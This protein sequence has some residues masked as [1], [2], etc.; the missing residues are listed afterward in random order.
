MVLNHWFILF[1]HTLNQVKRWESLVLQNKIHHSIVSAICTIN[2]SWVYCRI[3]SRGHL[4][5]Y[6][7]QCHSENVMN[8]SNVFILSLIACCR[9]CDLTQQATRRRYPISPVLLVMSPF[10]FCSLCPGPRGQ[11]RIHMHGM[12]PKRKTHVVWDRTAQCFLEKS[13]AW[14]ADFKTV[15][16]SVLHFGQFLLPSIFSFAPFYLI[17]LWVFSTSIQIT[18]AFP[19]FLYFTASWW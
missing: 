16:D 19:V 15:W 17:L 13:P 4:L 8:P 12:M 10:G 5:D 3:Q 2:H 14:T 18:I 1:T 6:C 9:N 11:G 7:N